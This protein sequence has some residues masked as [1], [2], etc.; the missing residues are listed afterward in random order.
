MRDKCEV[1]V[2]AEARR[3]DDGGEVMNGSGLIR[4]E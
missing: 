1:T 3:R 2:D 4:I